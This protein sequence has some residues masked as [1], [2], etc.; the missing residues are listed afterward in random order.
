MGRSALC[1]NLCE[2][3]PGIPQGHLYATQDGTG[4]EIALALPNG[5]EGWVYRKTIASGAQQQDCWDSL[6]NIIEKCLPNGHNSGSVDGPDDGEAF[7]G[8]YRTINGPGAKHPLFGN[9]APLSRYCPDPKPS[10]DTCMGG[11]NNNVCK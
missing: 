6:E 11:G 8:G 4:C 1:S 7:Q 9:D 5:L 10:C 3:P 2:S